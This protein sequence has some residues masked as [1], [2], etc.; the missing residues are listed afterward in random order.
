MVTWH[1]SYREVLATSLIITSF[2][3]LQLDNYYVTD[4]YLVLKLSLVQF[5]SLL[6]LILS[7]I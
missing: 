4:Y 7:V 3:M 5:I 6:L 2:P 1:K